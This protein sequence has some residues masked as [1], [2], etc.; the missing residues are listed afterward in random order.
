MARYHKRLTTPV[1]STLNSQ[2]CILWIE[3]L[4]DPHRATLGF[5]YI[6]QASQLYAKLLASNEYAEDRGN[7]TIFPVTPLHESAGLIPGYVFEPRNC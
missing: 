2:R 5:C 7:R 4:I 1:L 6:L 3:L